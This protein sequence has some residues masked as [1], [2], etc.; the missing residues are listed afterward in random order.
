MRVIAAIL[1]VLGIPWAL[2]AWIF[3]LGGP[4]AIVEEYRAGRMMDVLDLI[5]FWPLWAVHISL[6]YFIW[7]RWFSITRGNGKSTRRFWVL[8]SGHHLAWI[9][10]GVVAHLQGD[11]SPAILGYAVVV[12]CVCAIAAITTRS[13][14]PPAVAVL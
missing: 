7:S 10:F 12:F 8:A 3:V 1:F 4:A 6:G 2:I 14:P 11:S 13:G 5:L 9:A